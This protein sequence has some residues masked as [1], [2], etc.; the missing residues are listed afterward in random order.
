MD[1]TR[2]ARSW[3][4]LDDHAPPLP[5]QPRVVFLRA[6][7]DHPLIEVGDYT[8]FDDPVDPTGFAERNVLYHYG[9]ERLVIGRYCAIAT[10]VRFVMPGA[11]HPMLGVST[12][13][14]AIF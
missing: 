12:F 9:P 7:I 2:A 10:G 14:F 6:V 8:Y 1:N 4:T 11:N 13:P 5:G 3:A